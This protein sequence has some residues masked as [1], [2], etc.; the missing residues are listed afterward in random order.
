MLPAAPRALRNRTVFHPYRQD[1][2]LAYLTGLDE[3]AE[4][5]CLVLRGGRATLYLEIPDPHRARYD[6]AATTPEEAVAQSGVDDVRPLDALAGELVE[7]VRA[8]D[9]V[10]FRLGRHAR[11]DL[12]IIDALE[13]SS[14]AR[15]GGLVL[16]AVHDPHGPIGRM[17]ARKEEWELDRVRASARL[18]AEAHRALM[19]TARAGESTLALAGRFEAHV[20]AGGAL[21]TA[22]LTVVASGEDAV[23]LHAMPSRAPIERSTLVLVDAGAELDGYASDVT[24]TWPVDAFTPAQAHLY[25]GVL[26]AQ[27]A[28]IAA[29]RPGVTLA[30]VHAVACAHLRRTCAEL[31]LPATS[32]EELARWFPHSTS[33]WIGLDVHDA[34]PYEIA[35]EPVPLEEGM[36]LTVEPGLYVPHDATDA[37]A[38]LRGVGV[39]IEDTVIVTARGAEVTSSAAPKSRADLQALRR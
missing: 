6:G 2:D 20:R 38:A 33:H 16:R 23:V 39:R 19:Q 25:D 31:E 14:R 35:G 17:R 3:R 9:A 4:S 30:D 11:L 27:E 1:S 34:G 26:A 15:R 5:A 29:V 32:D 7:H 12:A 36:V 8:A 28:A 18:S 10:G 37:P 22:Y 24:R 13:A 21:R